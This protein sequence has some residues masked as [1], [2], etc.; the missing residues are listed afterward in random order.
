VAAYPALNDKLD[1]AAWDATL[2]LLARDPVALDAA[3]YRLVQDFLVR[4]GV[5]AQA[6]PLDSFA[7]AFTLA[8]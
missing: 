2:P 7:T 5:I 1:R 8:K 4:R 3:R 6:L